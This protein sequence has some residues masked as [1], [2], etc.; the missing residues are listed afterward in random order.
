MNKYFK[1]MFLDMEYDMIIPLCSKKE[2]KD[3]E[4]EIRIGQFFE[5]FWNESC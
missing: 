2:D 1:R 4:I 5:N 3:L